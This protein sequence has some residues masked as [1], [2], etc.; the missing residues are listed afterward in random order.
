MV[1]GRQSRRDDCQLVKRPPACLS[2]GSMACSEQ[3][4]DLGPHQT[5]PSVQQ[6]KGTELGVVFMLRPQAVL[7]LEPLA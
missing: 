6:S 5:R 3:A 4:V 7:R 1:V 2:T